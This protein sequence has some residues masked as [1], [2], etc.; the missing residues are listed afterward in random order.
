MKSESGSLFQSD[1][2]GSRENVACAFEYWS[3]GQQEDLRPALAQCNTPVLWITGEQD[4][5]FTRLAGEVTSDNESFEHEIIPETG[6]RLLFESGQSLNKLKTL[7]GDF[8]KR[9]L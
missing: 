7:I 1:I 9:I 5:K 4:E 2:E 8:Q 6:H 3:L